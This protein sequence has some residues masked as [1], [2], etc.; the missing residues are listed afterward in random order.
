MIRGII[1]SIYIT[2]AF[3][4]ICLSEVDKCHIGWKLFFPEKSRNSFMYT[5]YEYNVS[6]EILAED[7]DFLITYY[8]NEGN[9]YLANARYFLGGAVKLFN[10]DSIYVR[11]YEPHVFH[12][13]YQYILVDLAHKNRILLNTFSKDDFNLLIK[14][15]VVDDYIYLSQLYI[16]LSNIDKTV[17]LLSHGASIFLAADA[18]DPCLLVSN[19]EEVLD[20]YDEFE[21]KYCQGIKPPVLQNVNDKYIVE[22]YAYI[23]SDYKILKYTFTFQ[24]KSITS[25]DSELL[26][27]RRKVAK[28]RG[29]DPDYIRDE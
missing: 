12:H 4:Q 5:L 14:N 2:F 19:T 3:F 21:K 24:D 20:R 17:Y 6:D 26:V 8:R 23:W 25:I 10:M 9:D 18:I 11:R 28:L 1:I 13:S 29:I 7:E 22:L 16:V 15:F 27:D